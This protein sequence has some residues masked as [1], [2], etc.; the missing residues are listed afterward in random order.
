MVNTGNSVKFNLKYN[1]LQIKIVT[2]IYIN[3]NSARPVPS[4]GDYSQ[5]KNRICD[6]I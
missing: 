3:I 6:K 1:F 5:N 2:R 4:A